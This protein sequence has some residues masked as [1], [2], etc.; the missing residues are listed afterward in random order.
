MNIVN[1]ILDISKME[2]GHVALFI[3]PFDMVVLIRGV[4]GMFLIDAELKGVKLQQCIQLD[5]CSS[6]W[7][8][9]ISVDT[10]PRVCGDADRLRQILI[11]LVGNAVKF[12]S[13]SGTV[14]VRVSWRHT[15]P[16]NNALVRIA[17]CDTGIG[18]A[19]SDLPI[20]FEPFVQVD[21]SP[22]RRFGGTGLG[23]TIC[24]QLATLMGGQISVQSCLGKGSVFTVELPFSVDTCTPEKTIVQ[25]RTFA[26]QSTKSRTLNILVV[27]DNPVNQR[28]LVV[29]LKRIGHNPT[30]VSNGVEALCELERNYQRISERTQTPFGY[31][32][33]LMDCQMPLMD[34]FT[35]TQHI[36]KMELDRRLERTPI[37]A[38]TANSLEG[39]RERCLSFGMDDYLSKPVSLEL[40]SETINKWTWI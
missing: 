15:E 8:S 17:V 29:Q 34:G 30:A 31:D 2:Q 24:K 37:I 33:I 7:N 3:R 27:E 39:D 26:L 21:P 11:N 6:D 20:I 22:S 36:R 1:S 4:I 14:N 25:Q 40:I 9:T 18:I 10:I 12:T 16:A 28:V 32:I 19:N 38:L 13:E 5:E 35:A 23:L